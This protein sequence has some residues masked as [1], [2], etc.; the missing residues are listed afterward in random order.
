MRHETASDLFMLS[1][2]SVGASSLKVVAE[3]T[4]IEHIF[5]S[6]DGTPYQSIGKPLNRPAIRLAP[7]IRPR[8]CYGT[9]LPH[10]CR[11]LATIHESFRN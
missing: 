3:T 10:A 6:A 5:T 2:N 11:W 7:M 1:M 8:T 4:T 9:L